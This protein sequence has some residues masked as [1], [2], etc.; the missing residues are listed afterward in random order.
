MLCMESMAFTVCVSGELSTYQR[1]VSLEIP[2][3]FV[4]VWVR[5]DNVCSEGPHNLTTK[6]TNN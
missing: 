6:T 1:I 5:E 3:L 2:R 4:C